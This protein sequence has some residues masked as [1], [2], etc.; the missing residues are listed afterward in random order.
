MAASMPYPAYVPEEACG[1][2]QAR[3]AQR[4]RAVW[5]QPRMTTSTL[6]L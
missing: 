6:Y 3:Q 5:R 1:I 2:P 4:R